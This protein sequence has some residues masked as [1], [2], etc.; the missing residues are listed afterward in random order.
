M[1][2]S[3]TLETAYAEVL[4]I[5]GDEGPDSGIGREHPD[6]ADQRFKT[7]IALVELHRLR[8]GTY[9]DSFD[10]LEFLGAQDRRALLKGLRY[11]K[12]PDGY[13]LDITTPKGGKPRLSYPPDFWKGL[14]IRRTNVD[15]SGT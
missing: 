5:L 2:R 1:L 6:T 3:I 14:G 4:R 9:P 10:D 15:R 13:A 12:L 7:A 11:E 8:F